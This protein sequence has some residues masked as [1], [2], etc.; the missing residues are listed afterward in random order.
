MNKRK[1]IR[2]KRSQ[3]EY[4]KKARKDEQKYGEK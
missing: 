2:R 3:K 4:R 1:R